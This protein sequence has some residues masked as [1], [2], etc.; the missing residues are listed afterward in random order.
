MKYATVLILFVLL[1]LMHLGPSELLQAVALLLALVAIGGSCVKL[2]EY[3]WGSECDLWLGTVSL[4]AT[5]LIV[6]YVPDFIPQGVNNLAIFVT[7]LFL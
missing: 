1:V 3:I 5:G 6:A 2:E 7:N 4:I